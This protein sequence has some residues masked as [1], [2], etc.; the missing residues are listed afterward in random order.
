MPRSLN[1][2]EMG[3]ISRLVGVEPTDSKAEAAQ[4]GIDLAASVFGENHR[5]VKR[6]RQDLAA[7]KVRE[8]L[9]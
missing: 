3:T 7:Y 6:M 1:Q 5:D 8:G 9:S 2:R 4:K